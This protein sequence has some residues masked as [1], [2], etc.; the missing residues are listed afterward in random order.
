MPYIQHLSILRVAHLDEE[1][2]PAK[3]DLAKEVFHELGMLPPFSSRNELRVMKALADLCRSRLDGYSSTLQGDLDRL[4][5]ANL[6]TN[7]RNTL[8]LKIEEKR[9][10]LF[11]IEMS[12]AVSDILLAER[13]EA[14]E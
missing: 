5:Q 3:F 1:E 2:D 12:A 6:T 10:L 11:V 13:A 14:I 4:D 8:L 9:V 7:Q